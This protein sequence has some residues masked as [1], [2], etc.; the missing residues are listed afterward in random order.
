[1]YYNGEVP[2]ERQSFVESYKCKER[3]SQLCPDDSSF[4]SSLMYMKSWGVGVEFDYEDIVHS[5]EKI[6]DLESA[7]ASIFYIRLNSMIGM[8]IFLV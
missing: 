1:M 2:G 4:N 5:F 7:E 6:D 3:V 8:G